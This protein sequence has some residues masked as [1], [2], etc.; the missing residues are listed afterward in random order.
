M[1]LVSLSGGRGNQCL[2][3]FS[4]KLVAPVPEHPLGLGGNLDDR[5]C[6]V[7]HDHRV[8]HRVEQPANARLRLA[9]V[10]LGPLAVGHL[11]LESEDRTQEGL[12]PRLDRPLELVAHGPELA[13]HAPP[14]GDDGGDGEHHHRQRAHVPLEEEQRFP[15]R[16]ARERPQLE[17]RPPQ[18]EA[19]EDA[20]ARRR[21]AA[22]EPERGPEREWEAQDELRLGQDAVEYHEPGGD[23]ADGQGRRFAELA[24]RPPRRSLDGGEHE[25]GKQDHGGGGVTEPPGE[26]DPRG[27]GPGRP[28][29]GLEGRDTDRRAHRGG[30]QRGEDHETRDV[31]RPLEHA[32]A[33]REAFREVSADQTLQRVSDC[34]SRRGERG[35]ERREV[36]Q[37]RPHENRGPD[38]TP[39]QEKCREGDRGGGPHGGGAR[40]DVREAEARFSGQNV[41]AGQENEDPRAADTAFG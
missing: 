2:H 11:L 10:V 18:S 37:E 3:G 21:L 9:Q 38:A 17:Q 34:D 40:V 5:A 41:D 8:G 4:E 23:D 6:G 30:E 35:A 33:P 14:V 27:I 20:H 7:H 26:P 31:A 28:A 22:T 15:R 12:G 1:V 16:R 24:R 19:G 36:D 32:R 13:L 25:H 39:Q 29:R